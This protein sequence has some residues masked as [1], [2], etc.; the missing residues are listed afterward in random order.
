MGLCTASN[1]SIDIRSGA[2]F[3]RLRQEDG[4]DTHD[5]AEWERHVAEKRGSF[6]QAGTQDVEQHILGMDVFSC[7]S[8]REA[9]CPS[10]T[11]LPVT[12]ATWSVRRIVSG[13][14]LGFVNCRN[15]PAKNVDSDRARFCRSEDIDC[16]GKE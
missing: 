2:H 5:Q 8:W 1:G 14:A 10:P 11:L 6:G 13:R 12:I 7:K 3:S 16:M 15:I 4:H 9:S